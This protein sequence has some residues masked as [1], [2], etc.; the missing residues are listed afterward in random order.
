[1]TTTELLRLRVAHQQLASSRCR[2]PAEVV[3]WLGAMQAQE[4]AMVKWAVALRAPGTTEAAIDAALNDGSI[5]RTH[6]LRPTWHLVVAADIRWMLALTAPRVHAACAFGR[7]QFGLDAALLKKG[8][9]TIT[10]VL[11]TE[12]R[13]GVLARD[14]LVAA[15]RRAKLP[16]EGI[17]LS[18]LLIHAELG[19][20][21]CSGP[22]QG[23]QATYALLETRVPVTAA[24]AATRFSRS[25]ALGEL[26]RRYF[27]S[28][29]PAT[30][31]DFA[32]WSGLTLTEA[33]A[34]IA[35]LGSGSESGFVREEWQGEM[36]VWAEGAAEFAG[37]SLADAR[38]AAKAHGGTQHGESVHGAQ[39]GRRQAMPLRRSGRAV[40]PSFLMPDYD[41]YG[42]AYE[43][44]GAL[45]ADPGYTGKYREGYLAYNRMVI[46]DGRIVGSW[47]R[48][49]E[50]TAVD[51]EIVPLSALTA[52]AKKKIEQAAGRYAAFLGKRPEVRF[53]VG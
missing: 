42:I 46:V 22:R 43:D 9:R 13:E 25:E 19:G 53:Q 21:I 11:E 8:D 52:E 27:T 35:A 50:K 6:V 14:E 4:F 48:T 30:A 16:V 36:Y 45:F 44:R 10:R 3:A 28:R 18:H 15:L 1:M 29:G 40:L 34:G 41:E 33:R 31:R 23:K 2:E 39:R 32:W 26:A 38:D 20:L 7:K 5:L 17:P 47:K 37:A 12:G 51:I 24:T 49:E